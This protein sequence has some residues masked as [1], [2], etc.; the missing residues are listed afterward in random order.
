MKPD[1]GSDLRFLCTPPAFY[2]PVR[3]GFRRNIAMT[4][5]MVKHEWC[6]F[7]TMENYEDML[8]RF[9]RMYERDRRTD[10]T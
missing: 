5:G 3:G 1:I 9:D 2:A 8:I 6:G 10:T 7:P 4:F